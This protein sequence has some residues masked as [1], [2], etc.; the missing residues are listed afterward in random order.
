M[1]FRCL[2]ALAAVGMLGGAAR[3][4]DVASNTLTYS[5]DTC[6][7]HREVK[8]AADVA[9]LWPM[10]YCAGDTVKA[11][12]PGGAESTLVSAAAADGSMALPFNAGGLWT[13]E[14]SMQGTATFTVRHSLYGTLGDGTAA[15]PAKI[16][17]ADELADLA[18]AGTVG[19]DYVFTLNGLTSLLADLRIP[20]G[21]CL[22]SVGD[23]W[24]VATVADGSRHVSTA[25]SYPVDCVR[26]GPNR[27]ANQQKVLPIAYS[28]D[29]WLGSASAASTVTFVS[30]TGESTSLNLS[31]TGVTRFTF[32][33]TGAWTVRLVMENGTTKEA[34][35]RITAG[36]IIE[37]R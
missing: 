19:A 1:R 3:A 28:G 24:R 29:E 30:P 6:G 4:E 25:V 23:A 12:A 31:G 26:A 16:V 10:R 21:M 15:S 13:L 14:N 36:F 20:S 35:V 17:D 9:A 33:K 37:F 5:L 34:V 22:S 8:T 18:D 7:S 11:I 2:L 27:S 32:D